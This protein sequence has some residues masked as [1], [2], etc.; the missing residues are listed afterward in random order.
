MKSFAVILELAALSATQAVLITGTGPRDVAA[1]SEVV[2]GFL[3]GTQTKARFIEAA[4]DFCAKD[5]EVED[6]NYVCPHF[7]EAITSATL[8]MKDEEE[9]SA[10]GFCAVVEPYLLEM[11]GATRIPGIGSGPL[12]DFKLSSQ[13]PATV[14][15]AMLP[16][17]SI[18]AKD[19]PD[20]L[21]A[22]CI[23]QNCGHFL[24]SR[25]RWCTLDHKITHTSRVCEAAHKFVSDA[26]EVNDKGANMNGDQL[27]ELYADFVK[28]TGLNVDAY[29]HVIHNDSP[30]KLPVPSD[31][32]RAL[33]SRQLVHDA[34]G[35]ELRDNAASPVKPNF[36]F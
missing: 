14:G 25:T 2:E 29:E 7:K 15:N 27:C 3:K 19:A 26:V 6:K 5:K 20:F 11:R 28:E 34:D 16:Q 30:A 9:Q 4:V 18:V 17:T 33:V 24:P 13:C 23:N 21:Y 36:L 31:A 10:E 32:E 12:L 8:G 1:C 22:L 35:H